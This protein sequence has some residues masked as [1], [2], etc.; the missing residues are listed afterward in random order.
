MEKVTIF[1]KLEKRK[2]FTRD[3]FETDVY[4][5]EDGDS[6][7]DEDDSDVDEETLYHALTIAR[8][9]TSA[10]REYNTD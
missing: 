9:F 4:D 8:K 10:M 2:I 6:D 3:E 7:V 1:R 5:S